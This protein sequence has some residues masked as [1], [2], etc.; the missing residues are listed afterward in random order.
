M[1]RKLSIRILGAALGILAMCTGGAASAQQN[2]KVVVM[3]NYIA[4]GALAPFYY[5]KEKGY[6]AEEGIDVEL[7]EGR[8]SGPAVQAVAAKNVQFGYADF[9][10]TVKIAAKGAPVKMVGV[11]IQKNPAAIIGLAEKNVRKPEDIK[12]KTVAITA[13]DAPSQLWSL[14]LKRTGLK[15]SDFKTV[16]G[17]PQAKLNAVISGQADLLV[18]FA[19]EQAIRIEETLKKPAHSMLFADHGVNM[20]T[21]GMVVH[22]DLIKD[23]PDLI[24][25]FMRAVTKSFEEGVKNRE[26]AVDS[27]LKALPKAGT[28][29]TSLGIL[30]LTVPFYHTPDTAKDRLFRPSAKNMTDS[31]AVMVED[32]GLDKSAAQVSRYYTGEFL[33]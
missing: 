22:N 13:G 28:R 2:E 19:T 17:N 29:E 9:S 24:K 14:F 6:F 31:L 8:G 20:A 1:K 7:L 16:T 25:R 18:G 30:N 33:R 4:N 23:R 27:L 15:D 12:G 21:L 32:G 26:A 11:L 5:G 3:L 10:T